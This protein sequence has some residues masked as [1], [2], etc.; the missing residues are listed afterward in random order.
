VAEWQT[1]TVQ[2]RVSERTWGFNSPLAHQF[3]DDAVGVSPAAFVVPGV[4]AGVPA[5][6]RTADEKGMRRTHVATA[7]VVLSAGLTAS[8]VLRR[9]VA[10]RRPVA[11]PAPAT[12]PAV[13]DAPALDRQ[14]VVLPFARPVAAAPVAARPAAPARCGNSGGRT[15]AGAPCG[16][17]AVS[18]GRCHHHPIAA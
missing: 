17:R 1:R 18:G 6:A 13:I 12:A 14:A 7:L 11:S 2:V 8:A 5:S 9:L 15:K 16:A 10:R 4:P 3:E